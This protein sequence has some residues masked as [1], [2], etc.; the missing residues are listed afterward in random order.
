MTV[1]TLQHVTAAAISPATKTNPPPEEQAYCKVR[2]YHGREDSELR[3][4]VVWY[5][6]IIYSDVYTASA[7]RTE[8][9]IPTYQTTRYHKLR[10]I[11]LVH[12]NTA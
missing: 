4:R 8:V 1:G 12:F 10:D 5:V 2:G 3:D 11:I 7:F 6:D 9:L